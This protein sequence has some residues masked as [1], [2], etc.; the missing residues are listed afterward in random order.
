MAGVGVELLL[1]PP[2]AEV[3]FAPPVV[4][5]AEPGTM[6]EATLDPEP[7]VDKADDS[8]AEDDPDEAVEDS[9]EAVDELEKREVDDEV[10]NEDDE[11]KTEVLDDELDVTVAEELDPVDWLKPVD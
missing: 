2:P 7:V 4:V 5:G 3:E 1:P 8:E 6:V 11:L 9:D 10:D